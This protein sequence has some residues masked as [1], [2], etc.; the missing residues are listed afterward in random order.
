M[1]S[2]G[3]ILYDVLVDQELVQRSSVLQAL[4]S[5][6][7]AGNVPHLMFYQVQVRLMTFCCGLALIPRM[8]N[9]CTRFVEALG[10]I[11]KAGFLF[12]RLQHFA[13]CPV[14]K[15]RYAS[16]VQIERVLTFYNFLGPDTTLL[17]V[18]A[19]PAHCSSAFFPAL[20]V[21]RK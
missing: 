19:A 2:S 12:V 11:V 9:V 6:D 21:L 16:R 17:L 8:E 3:L 1:D 10:S 5:K 15:D 14:A 4:H 13:L 18:L 7:V 20:L